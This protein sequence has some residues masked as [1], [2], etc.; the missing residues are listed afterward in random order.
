[1]PKVKIPITPLSVAMADLERPVVEIPG[2]EH[3]PR[4]VEALRFV[5][6][7]LSPRDETPW[8][9]A[10]LS[11]WLYEAGVQDGPVTAVARNVLSYGTPIRR[12]DAKPGDVGVFWRGVA[13][14]GVTGH[15][16]ILADVPSGSLGLTVVGGNQREYGADRVSIKNLLVDRLLGIRRFEWGDK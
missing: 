4:I 11:L 5:K 8:C 10:I 6:F 15:T 7:A 2:S 1:M 14:D 9:A 16:G 13:D 3:H 12:H